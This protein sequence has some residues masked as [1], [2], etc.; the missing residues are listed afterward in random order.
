MANLTTRFFGLELKSPVIIGSSGLTI[1]IEKIKSFE[2]NGAGAVVLK[3]IF[4][5]EIYHEYQYELKN[6]KI[7]SYNQEYLD[8]FDYEIKNGT[9]EKYLELIANIKKAGISIPV[10]A[11]INCTSGS[12]WVFFAQKL[13]MAGAD[14]LE[15]NLF[16]LP[17]DFDRNA[18]QISQ[19][20]FHV[21][22]KVLAEV[23]IPVS[24]K[25][26]PY[27]SDLALMIKELSETGLSGITLF[28]RFYNI[29]IDI[30]NK[31]LVPAQILSHPTDYLQSLR[32]IGIMSGRVEC[33]LAASTGIQD[34]QTAIKMIMAG[35]NAVQIVSGLY[36]HG[37]DFV[38]EMVTG[39][40]DW[41]DS[42]GYNNIQELIGAANSQKVVNPAMYDRVQFMKH[43]GEYDVIEE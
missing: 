34:Y 31:E 4:E 5:E 22:K 28:N 2:E 37:F 38:K 43:F 39:I 42:H 11:S 17:S 35:A 1:S 6:Q 13:E 32:W 8:Y 30:E 19:Y 40:S 29:D 16:V 10:I 9:V 21:I 41:M 20:Y 23:T 24:I 12:E 25:I 26:S 15:L 3:S 27:F 33:D 18:E 7:A 14:A 36:K